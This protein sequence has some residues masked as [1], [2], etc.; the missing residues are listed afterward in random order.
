MSAF[1][2]EH[3]PLA[4]A[5][6]D[7]TLVTTLPLSVRRAVL[8]WFA[9]R[10]DGKSG[11]FDAVNLDEGASDSFWLRRNAAEFEQAD[12][13]EFLAMQARVADP[14]RRLEGLVRERSDLA[15]DRDV[16]TA[17]LDDLLGREAPVMSTIVRGPA[18]TNAADSILLARRQRTWNQPVLAMRRRILTL[19]ERIRAIDVESAHLAAVIS[20]AF[21]VAVS[22]SERLRRFYERPAEIY[23][24]ALSRT[25]SNGAQIQ[26]AGI[27]TTTLTVPVWTTQPCPWIPAGYVTDPT[28]IETKETADV[29]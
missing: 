28:P 1:V 17:E 29:L 25:A 15:A 21:S 20:V 7:R 6:L 10:G 11:V 4:V 9:G 12:R 13:A 18:E 19:E 26:A 14:S 8:A 27:G 23:R 24:R 22:R 2:R 16:L 5:S 3:D